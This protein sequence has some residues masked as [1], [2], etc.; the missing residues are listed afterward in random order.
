[1][2]RLEIDIMFFFGK[3]DIGKKRSSN[4]DF[5][6][7]LRIADDTVLC[8]VCDGMGGANGGNIASRT[9]VETFTEAAS[10]KL[11]E[12]TRFDDAAS[13]EDTLE[14]PAAAVSGKRETLPP[15]LA[16]LVSAAELANSAVYRRS[17]DDPNLQGM[18]TTLVAALVTGDK[19]YAINIG[20]SRLYM[21]TAKEG[22]GGVLSSEMRQLSHD[23]SYVQYLVDIGELR[24]DE[25]AKSPHRNIIT[26]AV[27]IDSEV[28]VDTFCVELSE[29]SEVCYFLLCSDGLTNYIAENEI[30]CLVL[31]DGGELGLSELPAAENE[32]ER[33]AGILVDTANEN[34]GGDN[35]TVVL[36]KYIPGSAPVSEEKNGGDDI[37]EGIAA[38][39]LAG[40]EI[41]VIEP[42]RSS[43][44]DAASEKGSK[45]RA[46]SKHTKP[47]IQG[48]KKK[49]NDGGQND[50]TVD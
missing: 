3:S 6:N 7:T 17:K 48:I 38:S 46:L 47:L 16:A 28:E 27:G 2:I 23:H 34:G 50:R 10:E 11:T 37:A 35:I 42:S 30:Q 45:K 24:P 43:V 29:T 21:I 31:G 12:L 13:C 9:A 20:D 36:M 44:S 15:P 40:Y 25:A 32:L 14:F 18:G 1:M 41:G 19:L 26:R 22:E 39:K 33:K 5:F 4:Q 8:V 49:E